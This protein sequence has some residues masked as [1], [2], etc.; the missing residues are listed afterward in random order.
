MFERVKASAGTAATLHPLRHTAAHRM[1]EDPVLPL[2]D[3]QLV[4]GPRPAGHDQ[5][6]LAPGNEEVIRRLLAH[7]AEQG[8]LAE[9]RVPPRRVLTEHVAAVLVQALGSSGDGGRDSDGRLQVTVGREAIHGLRGNKRARLPVGHCGGEVYPLSFAWSG[10]SVWETLNR[11][12]TGKSTWRGAQVGDSG[13]RS[14]VR[15]SQGR[16]KRPVGQGGVV[17]QS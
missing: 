10:R 13:Q 9:Q 1:A 3:V 17:T 16:H 8:R 6:Y 5:I 15:R 12:V 2:T 4:L 11:S 7:H 14:V